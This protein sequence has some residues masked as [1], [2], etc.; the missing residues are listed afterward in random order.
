MYGDA[1]RAVMHAL[2]LDQHV[3]LRVLSA[4]RE[5]AGSPGDC[6][7]HEPARQADASILAM[8]GAGPGQGLDAGRNGIGEADRFEKR[9]RRLVDALEIVVRQRPVAASLCPVADRA[10]RVFGQVRSAHGAGTT[11]FAPTRVG[12]CGRVLLGGN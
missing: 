11:I 8:N 10:V 12:R 4:K 3:V 7:E 2:A 6:V 1:G 9:Q 5:M